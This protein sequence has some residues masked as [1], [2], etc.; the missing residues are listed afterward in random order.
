MEGSRRIPQ[1]HVD[2]LKKSG[3]LNPDV[4][5]EQVINAATELD[6]MLT[7]AEASVPTLIGPFYIYHSLEAG[8][9][10]Q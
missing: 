1:E 10:E 2:L 8:R 9:F 7:E 5:L 6:G 3:I 4:T